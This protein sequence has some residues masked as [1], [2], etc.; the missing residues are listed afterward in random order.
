VSGGGADRWRRVDELVERALER[1][2]G[3][4]PAFLDEACGDDDALRREVESLIAHDRD[5]EFLATPAAAEAA[6]LLP[7]AA[8]P[9]RVG[10]QIGRFE[11][12]ARLGAGGMGEV[13]LADDPSLHRRVALK[14][15]LL[16]GADEERA[17]ERLRREARAA[18]GLA[19]P[20]VCRVFELGEIDGRTFIVMEHL[21]GETLAERLARGPVSLPQALA[22]GA[23]IAGALEEAHDKGLVHRDLKP[24]NVMVLPDGRVKVMDFGLARPQPS[25]SPAA[26]AAEPGATL[27]GGSLLGTPGYMAPEQLDGRAADTRSDVWALGCVL[28]QM[29]TG[30]RAF[31][32]STAEAAAAAIREGEPPWER[33]PAGTPEEVRRLLR[34]CLAKDPRQRLRHAGDLRLALEE[35]SE[36]QRAAGGWGQLR[37]GAGRSVALAALALIALAA[38]GTLAWRLRGDVPSAR[39]RAAET[40]VRG[41][42]VVPFENRTGDPALDSVGAMAADAIR[43]ELP[44]LDFL[45]RPRGHAAEVA[46]DAPPHTRITGA[47]YLDGDQLRLTATIATAAGEVLQSI[48]PVTGPRARPGAALEQLRQRTLGALVTQLDPR[49]MPGPRSRPPLYDAYRELLAGM[50]LF[51]VDYPAAIAHFERALEIDPEF[52]GALNVLATSYGNL[53]DR[54]SQRKVLERAAPMRHRLAEVERLALEWNLAESEGRH[55]DALQAIRRRAELE[56]NNHLVQYLL[57]YYAFRLNRPAESLAASDRFDMTFWDSGPRGDWSW[58]R[59]T[60]A[61]HLLGRHEEELALA[62]QARERHPSSL[63]ARGNE[64]YALAALGRIAELERALDDAVT[65]EGRRAQNPG[66]LLRAAAAELA[67]HG[68]AEAAANVA[69]RAVAWYRSRPAGALDQPALRLELGLALYLAGHL[70]GAAAVARE[71]LELDAR[72]HR[73]HSLAARVAARRG[74]ARTARRHLAAL[75]ELPDERGEVYLARARVS[76]LLGEREAALDLLREGL[77]QGLEFSLFFHR[78]PDL[79]TLAGWEPYDELMR[80]K[81]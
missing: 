45:R 53:G 18:A 49:F 79:A 12:V 50:Q 81:G 1:P 65:L 13:Y 59:R 71:L 35:A 54:E 34:R 51:G 44:R 52:F 40:T 17:H 5:D 55:L 76:A 11:L 29:L 48:E 26:S 22:W 6:G 68:H 3:E 56:P 25:T 32:G 72:D 69:A 41:V 7:G 39:G 62:R 64:A 73:H 60:D 30:E 14:F 4:R 24:A 47:Y 43:Q 36:A 10:Q 8:D 31:E 16:A 23:A 74:D 46:A 9:S 27:G 19:H 15:P 2:A 61:R 37:P 77:A 28:F 58:A 80:P 38:A 75:T 33:L 42:A 63:L 70:E 20:A 67:A 66:Q 57:A 78:D 21:E